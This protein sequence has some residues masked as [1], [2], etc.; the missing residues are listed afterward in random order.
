MK[1][2]WKKYWIPFVGG[3]SPWFFLFLIGSALPYSTQKK[4]D[5][6]VSSVNDFLNSLIATRSAIYHDFTA[7]LSSFIVALP[8]FVLTMLIF[9]LVK[10]EEF[11]KISITISL[12]SFFG[13]YLTS[14]L[15]TFLLIISFMHPSLP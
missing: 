6:A 13:G 1:E 2:F 12:A 8:F 11:K 3:L 10:K 5:A 7:Y 9:A 14:L 4:F 15:L